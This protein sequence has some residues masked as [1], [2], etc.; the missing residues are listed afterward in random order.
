V[1]A[2]KMNRFGIE[3]GLDLREQTLAF[4]QQHF[5]KPGPYPVSMET[6]RR[7]R[8]GVDP[9]P[10]E[11]RGRDELPRKSMTQGREAK[12]GAD[13]VAR[14]DRERPVRFQPSRLAPS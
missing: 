14:P 4:L 8:A 2:V 10:P 7:V 3:T 5:G 1:T 12:D 11:I 13:S 9:P 6:R